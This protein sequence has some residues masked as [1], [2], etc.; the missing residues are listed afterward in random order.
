MKK[1]ITEYDFTEAFRKSDNY[2][3][4]FSYEGLK[5][6]FE[7]LEQYEQDTGT[8][9]ELD[10]VSICGDFTEYENF[11]DIQENYTDIENM[12]QL[13]ENTMVIPV[14]ETNRIIIATY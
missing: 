9:L 1:T 8:E 6:L 2:K 11:K 13:Q 7:Y 12:E 4:S 5:A 14:P 3:N 10:I